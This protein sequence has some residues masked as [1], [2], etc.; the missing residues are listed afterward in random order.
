MEIHFYL[1][2][3]NT[4][5]VSNNVAQPQGIPTLTLPHNCKQNKISEKKT[6]SNADTRISYM[7]ILSACPALC[8]VINQLIQMT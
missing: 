3:K 4:F 8:N 6:L 7:L 1:S 2:S 5:P